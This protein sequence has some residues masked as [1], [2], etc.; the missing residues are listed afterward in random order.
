MPHE[1]M[2]KNNDVSF[3]SF[4]Y[5]QCCDEIKNIKNSVK[6]LMNTFAKSNILQKHSTKYKF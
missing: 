1:W 6:N 2:S 3:V 4:S 5:I